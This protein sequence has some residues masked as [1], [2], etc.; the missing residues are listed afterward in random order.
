MSLIEPET[1][2]ARRPLYDVDASVFNEAEKTSWEVSC[3]PAAIG[4]MFFWRSLCRRDGLRGSGS[5][6]H[7]IPYGLISCAICSICSG[8]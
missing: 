3:S 2:V 7:V 6:S 4:T 1:T 5:S 8:V